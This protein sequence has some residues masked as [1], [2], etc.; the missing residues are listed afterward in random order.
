MMEN[1]TINLG[2]ISIARQTFDTDYAKEKTNAIYEQLNAQG[3]EVIGTTDLVT[4]IDSAESTTQ[5][6]VTRNLQLLVIVQSTF[7]DSTMI[8]KIAEYADVPLLLWAVPE[9]RVGGRLRLNSFCG[10]NLAAHSLKR[11]GYTYEYIYGDADDK[12]ALAK[13]TAFAQAAKVRHVLRTTKIGRIGNHPDGFETCLFDKTALQELFGVDIVQFEL[14]EIFAAAKAISSEKSAELVNQLG[15]RID[16]VAT[17]PH[18]E[19][20]AQSMSVYSALKKYC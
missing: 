5:E 14:S 13:L 4:D 9:P 15:Q 8:I 19:S 20:T 2:F 12:A 1:S 16:G 10:I 17:L 3:Y 11:A 18:P 6:L 7:A